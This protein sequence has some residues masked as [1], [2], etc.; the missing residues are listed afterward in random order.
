MAARGEWP[1]GAVAVV[2]V[3]CRLPGEI[4]SLD[5]L[6]AAL[7]EGRD[8]V[9]EVP[10]GRF[11]VARWCRPGHPAP[12]KSYSASGGF[13]KDVAGF[14]ADFFGIAPVE[15][16]RVDPQQRLLLECA[17]EAFDDA[18]IDPAGLA[19]SDTA[20]VMG[21]SSRDYA[22]LLQRRTRMSN[23]YSMS[24]SASCNTA[25]R[26]SY[27][28][29]LRGPSL[30]VDTACSSALV[31]VHQACEAL[32]SGRAALALAGGANVL[33]NPAGFV[34]F[35]HASML[36]PTGR[37]RPFSAAADG[38]VRAEGGGVFVLKP[39][40]AALADGDRVHAVVLACGV[41]A[42]GRTAGLALP[43]AGAQAALLADV[44]G[45]A[46]AGPDDVVYVEAHGTGT[47]VG[48][49][50]ECEALGRALGLR[51]RSGALPVGSVK[52]NLGHLEAASG[53]AGL[54]KALL[55]LRE[56]RIPASLHA[57][58][59]NDAIDFPGLGLEPVTVMRPLPEVGRGVV[60]VNA[61][62]FGGANAHVVLASAPAPEKGAEET[63]VA[64]PG[65]GRLPLL[66][67]A[68]TS[69]ALSAAADRW[70]HHLEREAAGDRN[71][72]DFYDVAFTAWHRRARYERRLVVLAANAEE[73]AERLRTAAGGDAA[74]GTARAAGVRGGRVG[75]VF[76]GN[77]SQWAG[78]GA[79]LLRE[80]TAF[81]QEAAALDA[82]LTPLLG[83]SVVEELAAPADDGR[84]ERTEIGQPL[85]FTLQA[86]LA[87]AL[88]ARGI[89]PEAVAGHSVGEV[90]A[91]YCCGALDREAACRVIAERSRAQAVTAGSGRMAAVGLG[92]ADA[93]R[94][95]VSLGV[96]GRL[97]IAAVNGARDVTVSG[98]AAALAELEAAL[99]DREAFF[100]DL[101][102]DYAFHSPAMEALKLPL[103]RALTGLQ[104]HVP[105]IPMYSTVTGG[106]LGGEALDGRYWW[107]NVR[108]PVLFHD[109]M[110]AMAGSG[111]CDVLVEIGP[112]PVLSP[113]LR[114]INGG[115]A[116]PI[117]VVPT[118]SRGEDDPAAPDTAL[119]H[120][121][122]AGA[123]MDDGRVFPRRGRVVS[124]PAYPWQRTRHWTGSPAW[125][126]EAPVEEGAAAS[127]EH[128]LLGVRQSSSAAAWQQELDPG[129]V[130]WLEDHRVGDA[131]VLP[132]AAYTDMAL[133][134]GRQVFGEG[135]VEIIGLSVVKAL[136]VPVDDPT[137]N[138]RLHTTLAGDGAFTVAGRTAD[139]GDWTEHA[140]GR[141][142]RLLADRPPALDVEQIRSRLTG[143][144]SAPEH[145]ELCARAGLR[146][147]TTFR[148]LTRLWTGAG[149]VLAD[150]A[151]AGELDPRHPAHPAVLDGAL[152][153]L[154]PLLATG[155]DRPVLYL[156]T[157]LG[158]VRSW[159]TMPAQ[160]LIHLKS[161]SVSAQEAEWDVTVA[162]P[163]GAVALELSACRARR[164]EGVGSPEP[165][166]LTEV[167]RVAPR[168]GPLADPAPL[169]GPDEVLAACRTV[170]GGLEA[171][172]PA[173]L[174]ATLK[175][176]LSEL[177][178]H[179]VTAALQQIVPGATSF[180]PDDLIVAGVSPRHRR[181]LESLMDLSVQCGMLTEHGKGRWQPTARPTPESLFA[182]LLRDH[183]GGSMVALIYGICGRELPK[184]LRAE[185]DPL[186]L[187]FSEPDALAT[188]FYD[189]SWITRRQNRLARFALRT[190]VAHWP[191]ER[192]LRIL[193][194]GAGTGGT[195]ADLLPELPPEGTRYTYT[196]V[197]ASFFV[198]A[199]SRFAAYDFVDYQ[200][201]DLD[202]D[203]AEQ[204]FSPG[205]FD[206]VIA[207]NALH[208][209]RDLKAALRRIRGLLADGGQLL[210]AETH[211]HDMLV[212]VFGLLDSYWGSTDTGLRPHGPLLP[213]H[214]W[215]DVLR[216]CGFTSVAH[217]GDVTEPAG[218]DYSVLLAA[219]APHPADRRP[220]TTAEGRS[221]AAPRRWAVA[222]VDLHSGPDAQRA[223]TEVL[224]AQ[225]DDPVSAVL[226]PH[227]AGGWA[228]FL[229]D[230]EGP[231][232][233]VLMS[234]QASATTPAETTKRAVHA[235]AVLRALATARQQA[236]TRA[237]TMVWLVTLSPDGV[238]YCPPATSGPAA[239]LWGAARTL[240]NEHPSLTVRRVALTGA[241]A[242]DAH[243]AGDFARRLWAELRSPSE[244]D[245]VLLTPQGRFVTR[246]V[247]A[248]P[249][250]SPNGAAP[251][252]T[253]AV[254]RPG[255]QYRLAWKTTTIPEPRPGEAVVAVAAAAL[256]YRD[257]TTVT[258]LI[259]AL[260][261]DRRPDTVPLGMECAGVVCAVGSGV[262]GLS[263][264]DRV[265]GPA[266]GC[267]GTHAL[268]N[269][270]MLMPVPEGMTPAEA[271]TM[272]VAFLTVYHSL[273]HLARLAEGETLLVHGAAGG[274][275]LAA[276]QHAR[277]VG[278]R[279]IAT[280]G[281][282][283]KRHLLRL[284]GADHVLDSRSP[285]FADHVKE[286]TGG[287]GVDVVLNSLAG[288]SLTRSWYLLK[289]GGRFVK[290]GKRDIL[291][292]NAL[293]MGPFLAN[294]AFFGVDLGPPLIAGTS[295]ARSH[296]TALRTAVESGIYRPLPH[297]TIPA[298]RIQQAFT[299]LQHSRHFGKV[300]VTF[301]EPVSVRG[302]QAP[303]PLDENGTY[304]I[305]GGLSGLGAATARHLAGRGA[306][307]LTLLGRRGTDT[308][309]A[310]ALVADLQARGVRVEAHA[311]DATD[312]D[313]LRRVLAGLDADGRRLAGVVHAAMVLDDAPLTELTDARLHD[314]LAPKVTA[315]HCLDDLT[316]NRDVDFFIVYSSLA[317]LV[318]N[319]RQSAYVAANTAM[320]ALARDRHR[321]G[322]PALAVQ[323][324]AI[325]DTGYVHRTGL[326]SE[327][328]A[329]GLT[330]MPADEALAALDRLLTRPD[331][332]VASIALADWRRLSRFLPAL[333][334]P[335]TAGLLPDTDETDADEALREALAQADGEQALVLMEET[336]IGLLAQVL[337]AS[338]EH[339]DRTR[340][341]DQLGVDSLMGIELAHRLSRKL[342]HEVPV[343][344]LATATDFT[345][346]AHRLL[347]RL[348]HRPPTE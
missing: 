135:P 70:A 208:T 189:H 149:E 172:Q 37:C 22:D 185:S 143:S 249:P 36:S 206:L 28:F 138:P 301:D 268:A 166:V 218:S 108:E 226:T 212:P 277:H 97:V 139:H 162:G 287:Q 6:W 184:V 298:T 8:L 257:I 164:F 267:F 330:G 310:P 244:E 55:V 167:L 324:G 66:V 16:S 204:G 332:V 30:A 74:P 84:W 107:R 265:A 115:S 227:E 221:D 153:A 39:L 171:E 278:A 225:D 53:V 190:M 9:G 173:H 130:P 109:A 50:L 128:P 248:G 93:E 343:M 48:D 242:P 262:T 337:Q 308:P 345:S 169:P 180:C 209:A 285:H 263:V 121:L 72:L 14:D 219:R 92:L 87:A 193:E 333:A 347:I 140:R 117:E 100:K 233:I 220:V 23:A 183:P 318:G 68:R 178:A 236:P 45:A 199:R 238:T 293:P 197:S 322:L 116:R 88:G 275:G 344:E 261:L 331:I 346:I 247:P 3:A 151:A 175:T 113:Y 71:R 254:E 156:P 320:E 176:R 58:P 312:F 307:H 38:Y 18:G 145:Y 24:G 329:I 73:A 335:R 112:H 201:L 279:L 224:C 187:L 292:D 159:R 147:G 29:D 64:G 305:T 57:A 243:G 207:A 334:A 105:G 81:R 35:S 42:D 186:E 25:N 158:G 283:A 198:Q 123:R 12:G 215:P 118:L 216:D 155:N 240:A 15:A 282:P 177:I 98:Q 217:T 141:V 134:A 136:T 302:T 271:A 228:E 205:S 131:V 80:D 273:H 196:D 150:Y 288:E 303:I 124:L 281:S 99:A 46:G 7:E 31:A 266:D 246:V 264:G 61:F 67:S 96:R 191:A 54:L 252:W 222:C 65:E 94:L 179:F 210:A 125:W 142:R 40:E 26:L 90:A 211:T 237:R 294:T 165:T 328:A 311:V 340:R 181:L 106:L 122:A 319:L 144:L 316:R 170:L 47:A 272:P 101:G 77:G 32:R 214:T 276:L 296:L 336:L 51:R 27:V 168:P 17:V 231:A 103:Q 20:V 52:S 104:S 291:A 129:V 260:P 188:R 11:E 83:W 2:G 300:V 274:V 161:R 59:L 56:G 111:G 126:R 41:N 148:T 4:D 259:P 297:R 163:D 127:A 326:T 290:L 202:S 200:V 286:L 192:P 85:L 133:G 182:A 119:A 338:P 223:V 137:M 280:A 5:G 76:S 102:L 62:G 250:P 33:I 34:G 239:A 304:L 79:A 235:L 194:V 317:A 63:A 327:L 13:L 306:R 258:G 313:A 120:V 255:R 10:E 253:L 82:L 339:I 325:N 21:V 157:G 91:A 43:S 60:G 315:A 269:A 95:L 245:E 78:M 160:G 348:G 132:F 174:Y 154:L 75:F 146:Y 241:V 110:E 323:W 114:R 270:S 284:L 86:A 19:G 44:L 69:E 341:L 289:P 229:A 230:R 1:A 309:E 295:L 234:T 232:G 299:L 251:A 152:Q 314:V 321:A 195:T 342:G 203:P 213:R 49:P 256:N 89:V